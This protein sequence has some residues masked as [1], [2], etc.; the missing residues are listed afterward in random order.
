MRSLAIQPAHWQ[1]GEHGELFAPLYGDVYAS[2]SSAWGQAQAVFI[3]GCEL[4]ERASDLPCIR[5]LET[6]FGLG[7]N[8][9]ATWAWLRQTGCRSRLRYVAIEKH[10]FTVEDLRAA[11]A[12]AIGSAPAAQVSELQALAEKLL[13]AWPPLIPGFHTIALDDQVTLT[14][15]FG[16]IAPILASV[17]GRFDAIYL[18]GFAPDRNPEMWSSATLKKIAELAAP[19]ARL[20]SWCV[21]GTVRRSLTDAGF[22]VSKREGFGGKRD[23]L[24]ACWPADLTMQSAH[25]AVQPAVLVIGAGVAGASTARQLALRGLS[26]TVIEQQQPASGGSGN[27]VAVVRPEPGGD[28]NPI[29]AFSAAGVIWLKQW[30]TLHGQQVPHAF[31]GALRITRDQRRHDKLRQH[32]HA[33]P[34]NWLAEVDIAQASE[35]C[36]QRVSADAFVLPQ[37]GWIVPA[38]LVNALLDDPLIKVKTG[39]RAERLSEAE[40]GWRLQLSD[41]SQIEAA[42]VV[43]ADAFGALSPVPLAVDK[44][45]G[46]LSSLAAR[47]GHEVRMIICRDGYITP[48]VDGVHTIGATIQYNDEEASAR[49]SDDDENFQ[50]LERLLPGFA[51]SS[52]SLLSSR[53]SW[54]STTQDRLPLV[55]KIAEGLYASLGHGSRG[56]AC[57]P[58]CAEFLASLMLDEPLP[59]GDEWVARLDPLRFG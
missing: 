15:A 39:V 12:I 30:L 20:S 57:A 46:Q 19:D 31:C 56:I 7:V 43:L 55:G 40:A 52:E 8:F 14:L 58:M 35:L 53:V 26:V 50:R 27:P 48:A 32:A 37:A 49:A 38:A 29:A 10:P 18:D 23:R 1:S 34:E 11:L 22:D 41:G 2:R 47:E 44:A 6:G 33:T 59:L 17:R 16:D 25:K 21:A 24:F 36:G 13:A 9:L 3:D 5:L 28:E 54:R 42:R 4:P 51:A 45:R